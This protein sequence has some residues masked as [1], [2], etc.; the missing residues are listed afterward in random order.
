M[1]MKP[2]KLTIRIF[3]ASTFNVSLLA[4]SAMSMNEDFQRYF[5]CHNYGE[6]HSH[7][8]SLGSKSYKEV[9]IELMNQAN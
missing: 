8:S 3:L 4:G 1:A 6:C 2:T 9:Q 5:H 7:E